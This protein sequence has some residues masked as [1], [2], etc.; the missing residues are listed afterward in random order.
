MMYLHYSK[1]FLLEHNGPR[2]VSTIEVLIEAFNG[3]EEVE[4]LR[5]LSLKR[6]DILT[7]PMLYIM[8]AKGTRLEKLS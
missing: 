1:E 3:N 2:R 7:K 4:L 5:A 8:R 6:D